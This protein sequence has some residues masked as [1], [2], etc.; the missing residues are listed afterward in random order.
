MRK[1]S[2]CLIALSL[3]AGSPALAQSREDIAIENYRRIQA[4]QL[5]LSDLSPQEQ[6]DV[7]EIDRRVRAE[8]ADERSPEQRCYEDELEKLGDAPTYLARRSAALKCGI[9]YEKAEAGR[10]E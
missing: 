10:K 1:I 6:A 7:A 3:L 9:P 8:E 2:A 4:G 5:Q